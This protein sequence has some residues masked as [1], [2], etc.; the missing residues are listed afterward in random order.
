MEERKLT[1]PEKEKKEEI[2][3]AI[4]D[5]P[6]INPYA[7]STAQ[8]KK[9]AEIVE[10]ALSTSK[11]D[12][13]PALKGDQDELP[14]DLQKAIIDK[15]G[16]KTD[17]AVTKNPGDSAASDDLVKIKSILFPRYNKDVGLF[18]KDFIEIAKIL[19]GDY[20]GEADKV[21]SVSINEADTLS[22]YNRTLIMFIRD[23][24]NKGLENSL[25]TLGRKIGSD[26]SDVIKMAQDNRMKEEVDIEVGHKDNEPHMLRADLYR[27]AKYASE[28]FMMLKD[29]EDQEADFPHWWQAKII[30][31][32]DYLVGAKHYLDGEEKL[33]AID[34]MLDQPEPEMEPEIPVAERK[35]K[36]REGLKEIIR[37]ALQE[38]KK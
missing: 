25:K 38:S 27:I 23:P 34:A 31:A 7:V 37:K 21:A 9:V 22:D 1:A 28:L 29:Y 10:R 16:G 2:F 11:Y 5:K 8:A 12:D 20:T 30:K 3:Q 18:R 36:T 35:V 13:N 6:G 19:G 15:S 4:K 17:E 14:D 26:P 32:R 24:F 33:A